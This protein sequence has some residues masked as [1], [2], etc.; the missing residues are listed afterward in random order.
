MVLRRCRTRERRLRLLM[1]D[2]LQHGKDFMALDLIH[3][4]V[5]QE[6][7]GREA[8]DSLATASR[9]VRSTTTVHAV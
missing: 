3:R 6:T 8:G 9:D 2:A 1:P 5:S 7:G 4:P